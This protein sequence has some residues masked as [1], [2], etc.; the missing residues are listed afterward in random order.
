MRYSNRDE[1]GIN[2]ERGS[3]AEGGMQKGTREYIR[4]KRKDERARMEYH[5]FWRSFSPL[6]LQPQRRRGIVLASLDRIHDRVS[7]R[8]LPELPIRLVLE[9]RVAAHLLLGST[10]GE[11]SRG[12]TTGHDLLHHGVL[13]IR[14]LGW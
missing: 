3:H 10:S 11:G 1:V 7:A 2:E 9:S 13:A 5:G 6:W 4:D 8:P 14:D 12:C